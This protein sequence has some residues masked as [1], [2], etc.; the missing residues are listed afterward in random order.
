MEVRCDAPAGKAVSA[1]VL[2]LIIGRASGETQAARSSSSPLPG[3]IKP[4]LPY[5]F[6]APVVFLSIDF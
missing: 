6:D 2:A 1:W 4:L 5:D 3:G